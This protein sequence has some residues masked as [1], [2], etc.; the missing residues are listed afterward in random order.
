MKYLVTS[1]LSIIATSLFFN[2][3]YAS[4]HE[5]SEQVDE[6][7]N[8]VGGYFNFRNWEIAVGPGLDSY[9]KG[10]SLLVGN[11]ANPIHLMVN[12]DDDGNI[13][14]FQLRG[15][16]ISPN[17]HSACDMD[18]IKASFDMDQIKASFQAGNQINRIVVYDGDVAT[19]KLSHIV[20]LERDEKGSWKFTQ[21]K[22]TDCID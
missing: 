16:L 6:S 18:Q 1:L 13:K 21:R 5:N 2:F 12:D 4:T 19:R 20:V 14:Y 7:R 3:G 15:K 11:K 17:G 10:S 9:T 8:Y 22:E